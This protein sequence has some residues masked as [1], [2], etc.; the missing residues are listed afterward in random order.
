M[1]WF[2]APVFLGCALCATLAAA[3]PAVAAPVASES[4]REVDRDVSDARAPTRMCYDGYE[5]GKVI[6]RSGR[7]KDAAAETTLQACRIDGGSDA[8]A[9]QSPRIAVRR[10]AVLV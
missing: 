1:R 6:V 7:V 9:P 4:E 5:D 8:R 3:A 2:A 10:I